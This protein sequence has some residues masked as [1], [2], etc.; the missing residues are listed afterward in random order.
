LNLVTNDVNPLAVRVPVPVEGVV[1][2]GM[3]VHPSPLYMGTVEPGNAITRQ[4][5]VHGTKP[6]RIVRAESSNPGFRVTT[7]PSAGTLQRV[8]VTFQAGNDPGKIVSRVRILTDGSTA[9]LDVE[10]N[11]Q[12]VGPLAKVTPEATPALSAESARPLKR[13]ERPVISPAAGPASSVQ[14]AGT[15][16]KAAPQ[17]TKPTAAGEK[18]TPAPA[19]DGPREL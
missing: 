5:V 10:V 6:F 18:P 15:A 1:E 4:L 12:V 9:P 13:I 14:S 19:S 3:A 17:P 2:A 11:A 8:S 7:P 16:T